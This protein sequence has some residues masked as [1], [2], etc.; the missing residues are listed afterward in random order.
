MEM[1]KR[2]LAIIAIFL[3]SISLT[4]C[5]AGGKKTAAQ[6]QVTVSLTQD[7]QEQLKKKVTTSNGGSLLSLMKKTFHAKDDKGFI[8]EINGIKQDAAQN[9]YWCFTI[10]GK[11]SSVGAGDVRLKAGEKY[12]FNLEK[13]Q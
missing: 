8:T 10:N 6:I 9:K 11:A 13:L 3:V 12:A 2:S 4:A 7:G 5:K 1:K